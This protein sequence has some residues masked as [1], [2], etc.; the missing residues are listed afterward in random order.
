[1]PLYEYRCK[2]CEAV[3]EFRASMEKKEEMLSSL[4]CET[5]GSSNF[6][7]VFGG[8]ALTGSKSGGQSSEPPPSGSC[9]PGGMCGLD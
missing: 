7:Q 1:M 4:K 5:C 8:V 9:C 3:T 6:T 2:E